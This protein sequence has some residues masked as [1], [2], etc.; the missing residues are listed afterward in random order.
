MN[1]LLCYLPTNS[2]T[3][4]CRSPVA[5]P[6]SLSEFEYKIGIYLI[7][8]SV[9]VVMRGGSLVSKILKSVLF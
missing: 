5:K 4:V 1:G 9:I 8:R 2:I 7:L 3:H 6:L